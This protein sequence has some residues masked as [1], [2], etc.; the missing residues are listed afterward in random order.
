MKLLRYVPA[1]L[2]A[3]LV[4]VGLGLIFPP[5]AFIAAGGFLLMIDRRI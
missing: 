1:V 3:A 2:G 4:C 5:L